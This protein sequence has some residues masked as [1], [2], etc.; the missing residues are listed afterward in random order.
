M[1][2]F[3]FTINNTSITWCTKKR[4]CVALSSTK[5]E[6]R[7]LVEVAKETIQLCNLFHEFGFV[8]PRLIDLL[9]DNQS[10]IEISHNPLYHSK[11]KHFKIHLYYI[12][13]VVEKKNKL[14]LHTWLQIRNLLISSPN[15]QAAPSLR[16]TS[17]SSTHLQ[18]STRYNPKQNLF[19]HLSSL[20]VSAPTAVS[21]LTHK[22]SYSPDQNFEFEDPVNKKLY[23]SY[24][25]QNLLCT[26]PL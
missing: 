11:T 1:G 21:Q 18:F 5:S 7:A 3:I 9:C 24:H 19:L 6:Y 14:V 25:D 26:V 12:Q 2:A 20:R 23:V 8:K 15:P 17:S 16:T 4:T 22:G 10:S 13:D